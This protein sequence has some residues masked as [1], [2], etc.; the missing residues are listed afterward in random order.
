[1]YVAH[2]QRLNRK[3]ALKFIAVPRD[4]ETRE[5]VV[6]E[7]R[8]LAS[9]SHRFIV[10]IYDVVE[11]R[12][13]VILV[14]E[15]MPGTDLEDLLA[16]T[17]LDTI[18]ILQLGMDV[19][20]ALAAAHRAGIIHR[21]LKP[22]NVLVDNRG[23]IKLTD[24]GIAHSLQGSKCDGATLDNPIS[25]SYRAMS[26]EQAVGAQLDYRSDLFALGLL[27]YRL[28]SGRHPFDDTGNELQVLQRIIN[29][30]HQPLLEAAEDMS[31]R[32]SHLLDG[33]LDKNS[34]H[35]P[36]SAL[37]VRQELLAVM[38]EMPMARG[39]PLAHYVSGAVREEDSLDTS[40]EL[41]TGFSRG[42]RSHLLSAVEWGPWVFDV[43][44]AGRQAALVLLVCGVLIGSAYGVTEWLRSRSIRVALET[45]QVLGSGGGPSVMQLTEILRQSLA[46]DE[47]YRASID[48]TAQRLVL[49]VNCNEYICGMQLSRRGEATFMTDYRSFVPGASESAWRAEIEE[50]LDR[51]A[52][53]D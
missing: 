4:R 35:R 49:Q 20:A 36:A 32:L 10:Q 1:M 34:Q 25:G 52:R 7:A 18:A 47:R 16:Q 12:S 44:S 22:A 33:L 29:E 5:R 37:A 43:V 50:S 39:H 46:R 28:L 38:R 48:P 53:E 26:P 2:D 6:V 19:C 41:P 9:I 45:P 30:A 14:M 23:Q 11:V 42:A 17:T 24:F 3:V 40:V 15:Y 27:L 13:H 51:L 31:P 8:L 21:D